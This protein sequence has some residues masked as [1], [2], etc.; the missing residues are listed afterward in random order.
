MRTL[1][2]LITIAALASCNAPAN[3]EV[4]LSTFEDSASY[5]IG[6]TLGSNLRN[7]FEIQKIEDAVIK[8]VIVAGLTEALKS[9]STRLSKE[10][11]EELTDRFFEELSKK[12]A[13]EN[14]KAGK[15]FLEENKGKP[16]VTTTESGLQYIVLKEGEGESPK[17]GEAVV[18]HY[19]GKTLNGDVWSDTYERGQP[20]TI[21]MSRIL[22]GWQEALQLMKPGA[23]YKLF[24]PSELAFGESGGP[25][26][27]GVGPNEV[28]LL[29]VKLI[30]VIR[31]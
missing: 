6:A 11:Y 21:E 19:T 28:I 9:D 29:D 16:G 20:I 27:L 23:E 8:D 17:L 3:K 15:T 5:A 14:A 25:Q 7:D 24:L 12:K 2:L 18:M 30:D 13:E 22:P 1:T 26:G 4:T 10:E 31:E